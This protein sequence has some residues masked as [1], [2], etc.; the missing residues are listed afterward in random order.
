[1]ADLLTISEAAERLQVSD[2]Q[3]RRLVDDGKLPAVILG[4]R[5]RRIRPE[6]LAR[7]VEESECQSASPKI[8]DTPESRGSQRFTDVADDL[9]AALG[10]APKPSH[11]SVIPG[12]RR[13]RPEGSRKP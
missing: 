11:L 6:T 7:F 1:M 3:V 8:P 10:L 9:D 2:R 12:S 4:P 13:P 5:T